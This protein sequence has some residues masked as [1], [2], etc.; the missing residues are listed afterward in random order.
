MKEIAIKTDCMVNVD[1]V[2]YMD[3]RYV[4]KVLNKKFY[5]LIRDIKVIIQ[6]LEHLDNKG[7]NNFSTGRMRDL[8][9]SVDIFS[10]D[11]VI[12]TKRSQN[13]GVAE[14]LINE[15]MCDLLRL[16]SD[17]RYSIA[18]YREWKRMRMI[19]QT[20]YELEKAEDIA[21]LKKENMRL[22]AQIWHAEEMAAGERRIN[23]IVCSKKS[24]DQKIKELVDL[25]HQNWRMRCDELQERVNHEVTIETLTKKNKLLESHLELLE[26]I[27]FKSE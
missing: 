23:E 15:E 20:K 10:Y 22:K 19:L 18:L 3:G 1:G 17:F 9:D 26:G 2:W 11:G 13:G 6:A 4:A 27:E 16:Y 12:V 25:A 7:D 24:T 21:A 5:H 8:S 14:I